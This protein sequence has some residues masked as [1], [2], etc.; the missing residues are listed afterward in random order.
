MY[1]SVCYSH[2]RLNTEQGTLELLLW[3]TVR[4]HHLIITSINSHY[5]Y[6]YNIPVDPSSSLAILTSLD[7]TTRTKTRV[8]FGAIGDVWPINV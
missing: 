2:L 6:Q 1:I 4:V 7:Q 3:L 5:C 8:V